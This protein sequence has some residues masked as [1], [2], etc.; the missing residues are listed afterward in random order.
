MTHNETLLK[1]NKTEM[2]RQYQ[3]NAIAPCEIFEKFY[4]S[5]LKSTKNCKI[6]NMSTILSS[7]NF[8]GKDKEFDKFQTPGY[9]MSKTALN[10]YTKLQANT[11]SKNEGDP[12]FIALHPGWV[13]TS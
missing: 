1:F 12:I 10:M 4:N 2:M 3:I 5:F 11:Y 9:R 8:I 7:I 13:D 6:I